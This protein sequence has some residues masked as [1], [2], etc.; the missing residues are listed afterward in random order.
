[1]T[2]DGPFLVAEPRS[3]PAGKRQLA[4]IVGASFLLQR[5]FLAARRGY[6]R[7]ARRQAATHLP[8][9]QIVTCSPVTSGCRQAHSR[10]S[11]RGLNPRLLA[12]DAVGA[13]LAHLA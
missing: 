9:A 6:C 5:T 12:S 10:R 7:T 4:N 1:M 2:Q 8:V 3:H 11:A 13:E